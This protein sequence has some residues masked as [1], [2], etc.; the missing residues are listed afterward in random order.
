VRPL[1]TLTLLA[2]CSGPQ[3]PAGAATT[4]PSVQLNERSL[5][6]PAQTAFTLRTLDHLLVRYRVPAIQPGITWVTLELLMPDGTVHQRRH[7]A[8]ADPAVRARS[9]VESPD[10]VP[11]PIDVQDAR[12]AGDQ[13]LLDTSILVGG[14]NLQR[15]PLFGRWTVRALVDGHPQTQAATSFDFVR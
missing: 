4:G 5:D 9:R 14:S 2:A 8:F 12:R 13:W 3:G 6:D 7:L 10:G 11:H 15:H 1:L